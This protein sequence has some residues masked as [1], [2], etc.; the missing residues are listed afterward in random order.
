MNKR[1]DTESRK[2]I[3]KKTKSIQIDIE[4]NL[5]WTNAHIEI[6]K[7]LKMGPHVL[8]LLEMNK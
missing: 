4:A 7:K 1:R 5:Q 8:L 3:G 2:H 6:N